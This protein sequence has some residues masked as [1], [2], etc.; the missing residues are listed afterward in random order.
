[1]YRPL[2]S[3]TRRPAARRGAA[4]VVVPALL[5]LFA[6]IALSF[7]FYA[8][9]EATGSRLYREREARPD[10]SAPSADE[11]IQTFLRQFIYGT[12]DPTITLNTGDA[13]DYL[14][15]LRGHDLMS[16]VY[17]S[18]GAPTDATGNPYHNIPFNGPGRIHEGTTANAT[19][20][21]WL[22][23]PVAN[24]FPTDRAQIINGSLI[25]VRVGNQ[26]RPFLVD[27]EWS[28][29]PRRLVGTVLQAAPTLNTTPLPAPKAGQFDPRRFYVGPNAPYTYADLNNLYMGV[30]S[31]ATG[32]V[33]V[34]SFYRNWLFNPNN[35]NANS[36]LG[37]YDQT[38]INRRANN[39][40]WLDGAGRFRVLRPRPIDQL[41]QGELA[42]VGIN[43]FPL[44]ATLSPGQRNAVSTLIL[45]KQASGDLIPYPPQDA[46]GNWSGDVQ[47]LP[48]HV[49]V[50]K[51]D[52]IWLDVGL[53]P[54]MWNGKLVKP[55]VAVF[56]SDS[57]GKV[58][59]TAH[60]NHKRNG[61]ND[62]HFSYI[63]YGPWEVN[64]SWVLGTTAA[65][66]TESANVVN[67]RFTPQVVTNFGPNS[68]SGV[69]TRYYDPI[70]LNN[71]LLGLP[72]PVPSYSEIAWSWD[73]LAPVTVAPT[74][75]AQ[76]VQVPIFTAA[77]TTNI[78]FQVGPK[79]GGTNFF[80]DNNTARKALGHPS[81]YNA[82][83]WA[84]SST[85]AAPAAGTGRTYPVSDL[86]MAISR[87]AD[88]PDVVSQIA[89][90]QNG[91]AFTSLGA[92]NSAQH[93]FVAHPVAATPGRYRTDPAHA[94]RYLVT[95]RGAVLDVP[96]LMPN[97][98]KPVVTT[99][100]GIQTFGLSLNADPTATPT[101][102]TYPLANPQGALN[103]DEISLLPG[104]PGSP[105][106]PSLPNPQTTASFGP[107]A[108]FNVRTTLQKDWRSFQAALGPI[109]VN[110][111]LADYRGPPATT[112]L[113]L[114]AQG[115]YTG[116]LSATTVTNSVF[117][118]Q[119]WADRHNLAKD[120]FARL[121]VATGAMAV[122]NANGDVQLP[123]GAAAPYTLTTVTPS[124]PLTV[125]VTQPQYDAL[126]YLAQL[127]VN[128]VDY[129]DNDDISTVFAW[130]PT[131]AGGLLTS[132]KANPND[133]PTTM[134][135]VGTLASAAAAV[136][137]NTVYGVER[138]RLV[139]NESYSEI[140]N[141]PAEQ[142][143]GQPINPPLN[144]QFQTPQFQARVRFWVELLNPSAHPYPAGTATNTGPLG[145]GSVAL[146][147]TGAFGTIN[148][149]KLVMAQVPS[150]SQIPSYLAN[151]TNTRG[152]LPSGT[153]ANLE[154]NFSGAGTAAANKQ[155][156]GANGG[157]LTGAIPSPLPANQYNPGGRAFN[158]SVAVPQG[159][160][161]AG[162]TIT[163]A[164]GAGPQTFEFN[165]TTGWAAA[166][167]MIQVPEPANSATSP[168]PGTPQKNAMTYLTA[169]PTQATLSGT[170]GFK[171]H[172]VLLKRLANPYL[173]LNLATAD[174][175]RL[176][177]D[178]KYNQNLPLNPYITVD[179]M[180]YVRTYDALNRSMD[181]NVAKRNPGTGNS[182]SGYDPFSQR[183]ASG[184]IQPYSGFANANTVGGS[185]TL[186]NFPN[187][188][189]VQQNSQ[190]NPTSEPFNT[191]G[192]H[193]GQSATAP[194]A[195]TYQT[196]ASNQPTNLV[197]ATGPARQTLMAPF[198]MYVHPDRKLANQ[199]E[200]LHV[201][202]V[203]PHRVTQT[204]LYPYQN[205]GVT[206]T[207]TAANIVR[208]L[209][210]APWFWQMNTAVT[211][212]TP[213][214][215]SKPVGT[216][217][218]ASTGTGLFRALEVLRVRPWGYATPLAGKVH[219]KVNI[220]TIQDPRVLLALLDPPAIAG[221]SNQFNAGDVYFNS[222]ASLTA[223]QSWTLPPTA[224]TAVTDNINP[225]GLWGRLIGST[226]PQPGVPYR[227]MMVDGQN[228]KDAVGNIYPVPVPGRTYDDDPFTNPTAVGALGFD[229]PF[230]P[231][232]VPEYVQAGFAGGG[233]TA[234]GNAFGPGVNDT[235]LRV[236]QDPNSVAVTAY[237]PSFWLPTPVPAGSPN[238]NPN[239]AAVQHPYLRAEAARKLLNNVTT[240][241]GT[242][243]VHATIGFFEVRM[244]GNTPLTALEGTVQVGT[245]ATGQ[246]V[247]V[248]RYLLGKEAYKEVP[249][250]LR[251]QFFAVI[252]R[253]NAALD[254]TYVYSAT[255]PTMLQSQARPFFTTL[256][257]APV[258][259]V[260]GG[261][262]VWQVQVAAAGFNGTYAQVFVDGIQCGIGPNS[263]AI[264]PDNG[265]YVTNT[266]FVGV[267][268][269]QEQLAV[270]GVTYANGIA[271]LTT[272]APTKLHAAGT[273]V[274]NVRIGNPGPQPAFRYDDPRY[275]PL[276]PYAFWLR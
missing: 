97:Y 90:G 172:V 18:N 154:Y 132:V 231:F 265:G 92:G 241:S 271:T 128:I 151:P 260:V 207:N 228:F 68:R 224:Q 164:T 58:N 229:R 15:V 61:T 193:N 25:G 191:F 95:T 117:I 122:V 11:A 182:T 113:A 78:P 23:F 77:A 66:Q 177:T 62:Q 100:A 107:G 98:L 200:L 140:A 219:G 180:D 225:V 217:S 223:P 24:L 195:Q 82:G 246:Q 54:V 255:N 131:G 192:R 220:N 85:V 86:R 203:A 56:V 102:T 33:V 236:R 127:A 145:D 214:S 253:N 215:A 250:D 74:T 44:P 118:N 171:R 120:I 269:E 71:P 41:T 184:K 261:K 14:S 183:W 146:T 123:V 80:D 181:N 106:T 124:G 48:G 264:D 170:N 20:P 238:P 190:A 218:N 252:D 274:T 196:N 201:Q 47:N 222:T 126:R 186:L 30:Y 36:R 162:P 119:A 3:P 208:D 50:Q 226:N 258:V 73:R 150:G 99:P 199:L 168:P 65:A 197:P 194:A 244:N 37:P 179:Y 138:P 167:F 26:T 165:P 67:N 38:D 35:Q 81:L 268:A 69:S 101:A 108:D 256:E 84:A 129:I 166:A 178:P 13:T 136:S 109:D 53:P 104:S 221:L 156:V 266:I 135:D 42:S 110:R 257:A 17:G 242:F 230:K 240:V 251:R 233:S 133:L 59:L 262:A 139:I 45:Q 137:A 43:Q 115:G 235:L 275:K 103:N 206:L 10:V 125:Q 147:A 72:V 60:G 28:N 27:P 93:P 155:K 76:A 259:G 187:S 239:G 161:V 6:L 112:P 114:A 19:N 276:V 254:P 39:T 248:Q 91:Y 83:E 142:T 5:G 49:G 188:M 249:G 88:I 7:V 173:P 270:T 210:L 263:A 272:T 87:Y 63:G 79:F 174:P 237:V 105:P 149:Y 89:V 209:G 57:D 273:M 116:P 185:P 52:S 21:G 1:M 232:G 144:T 70:A 16:R 55:L 141:D 34:P 243:E 227:T 96:G 160:V 51:N 247:Q 111:P 157:N 121:I 4:M 211:Q 212:P 148:P 216:A 169:V 163:P 64:P 46:D 32:L 189:V 94:H 198:D 143:Q 234:L 9:S 213:W 29:G 175:N 8:D 202:A 2:C 22:Q 134:L 245:G 75:L 204:T 158:G 159:I 205:T 153:T 152:D 31:P 267:G 40:D 12:A 130:N 176:P